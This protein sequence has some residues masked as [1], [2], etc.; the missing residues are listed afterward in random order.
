MSSGTFLLLV[1]RDGQ[2]ETHAFRQDVVTIGRSNECDLA[3]P[4]RLISRMHCRIERVDGGFALVDLGAQNPARLRNR[5]VVRAELRP[6]E[7]FSCGGYEITLSVPAEEHASVEDTRLTGDARSSHDLSTFLSI[8]TA[9]NEQRELSRLLT[10]IVDAAIELA[11]AERGFLI[12]GA[13]D[14][15]NVE[16]ARNFAQEEVLSPEHK[17]SRTI[18]RR[19]L[20]S[21]RTELTT[22]AQQDDRFRDLQ[23]V[24]DLRLRSVLCLPIRIQGKVGGVLYVDNR[25][26]QQVFG[27]REKQLLTSLCDYAGVAIQNARGRDELERRSLDLQQALSRVDQLNAALRGQLQQKTAELS[28][29]REELAIESSGV[30]T[31]HDYKFIVGQGRA[32]RAVFALLD[33][34]IDAEDPVLITGESGTGKELV[35]RAIHSQSRRAQKS[36]VSENCA[37]LPESLLESELFGYVKGAFTGATGTKKGLL[38][39]ADGG[40]LFLDE[41]GDM[42]L[43]LQKKLLRA[44]QEG[45]VRPLGSS[46]TKKV[47][48]R[49]ITATNR[50]LEELVREG[51]FREDLYYR[52]SVLP[53][54]LPPLR[55]RREDIPLLTKRF[56]AES[57]HPQHGRVRL[58]P[59]ALQRLL[60]YAW[61]GNVRELQNELRRASILCDGVILETHLA[62]HVLAGGREVAPVFAD[63]GSVP[64]ERG[65]T[66]PD[67]V[68]ELEVREIKK[69]WAKSGGN[70]SR[71]A[72]MLGL[73]RFALQRKLEKYA[74]D[75]EA[76]AA[77][78]APTQG[79]PEPT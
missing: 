20:A 51:D 22:N 68:V 12:L 45:E 60:E 23:S 69:A 13:G 16:V 5:P 72:E 71:S 62:P 44:L 8:A 26:Q 37:A 42:T 63:D 34:Y 41:V 3:L 10:Q 27:E 53:I 46:E 31:K 2:T 79:D 48:V 21:G 29:I 15:Q 36:F 61:P 25:L 32:M 9:L 59:A 30:R 58:D 47:D 14:E 50:N 57:L 49:L 7:S 70:K 67:M 40:V 1:A 74:M 18:A 11:S 28:E 75:P 4:D 17:V 56:L 6:G 55:E 76:G 66:L 73:S 35:A 19:V 43:D 24:A 65:T 33:K 64:A 38:E 39:R 54:T 78:S 77:P 52:I